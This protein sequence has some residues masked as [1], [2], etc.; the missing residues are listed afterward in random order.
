MCLLS[1]LLCQAASQ[2][3]KLP[4][5][6]DARER[7][8]T[9]SELTLKACHRRGPVGQLEAVAVRERIRKLFLMR[10]Q[11]DA[12]QLAAQVLQ[13]LDHRLPPILVETA[14]SFIDDHRFNRTMLPAG[15]LTNAQRQ[16]DGDAELLAAAQEGDVD[17]LLA[18]LT[19][20][21]AEAGISVFA[22]ST[23]ETDYLLVKEADLATA[24]EAL[25][26]QGHSVP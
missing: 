3:G 22:A 13:F 25:R 24:P 4:R 10:H 18:S 9:P 16:A 14:K 6:V 19:A 5:G 1:P 21:L 2:A 7:T 12:A 17:R 8:D 11:H 26:K 20:P 23:F 15:V